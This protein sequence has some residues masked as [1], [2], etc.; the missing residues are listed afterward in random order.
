MMRPPAAGSTKPDSRLLLATNSGEVPDSF[1]EVV[2]IVFLK[3]PCA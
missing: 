1:Y 2:A 3:E